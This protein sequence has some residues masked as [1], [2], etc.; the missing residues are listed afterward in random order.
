[1]SMKNN[2]QRIALITGSAGLLGYQHAAALLEMDVNVV[3]SD[4]NLDSLY[5]CRSTS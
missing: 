2:S 3:L 4:I 5:K 1:M